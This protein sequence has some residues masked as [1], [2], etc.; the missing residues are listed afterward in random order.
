MK[1]RGLDS[2]ES[3]IVAAAGSLVFLL[4][5]CPMRLGGQLFVSILDHFETNRKEASFPFAIAYLMRSVS[6]PFAGFV[7]EKFGLRAVTIA[8]SLFCAIGVGGCFFAQNI[9]AVDI[10]LGLIYGIGFGWSTAVIPEIINLYFDKHRAKAQGIIFGGSGVG[11]FIIPPILEMILFGVGMSGTFLIISA[12]VLHSVPAAMLLTKR[13]PESSYNRKARVV[14]LDTSNCQ[15]MSERQTTSNCV[16]INNLIKEKNEPLSVDSLKS[17][18]EFSSFESVLEKDVL[19]N[20]ANEFHFNVGTESVT[21]TNPSSFSLENF[22]LFSVAQ[23]SAEKQKGNPMLLNG[24]NLNGQAA[25]CEMNGKSMKCSNNCCQKTSNKSLFNTLK[26]LWQPTFLVVS[27]IQSAHFYVMYIC[28]TIIV[29]VIRDKGID[30]SQE[31]Y[32]VMAMSFFDTIGRFCLTS[33]TDCGYITNSNFSAVCFAGMGLFC[34]LLTLVSGFYPTMVAISAL[35]L[36]YGGNTSGLPGIVTD[37]FNE[38]KRSMAMASRLTLYA[39]MSF[40]MSPLIGY[41]RGN[42]GSYN[43]LLYVMTSICIICTVTLILLPRILNH[44]INLPK[45]KK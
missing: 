1:R 8:G 19:R 10:F 32:F 18:V 4:A 29:D 2:I 21:K 38:E 7:G 28:W 35:G 3:W 30:Y 17:Y 12:I 9:I 40:T 11:A 6:G 33:V 14:E 41:F 15:T 5:T 24:A 20:K 13:L 31:V 45:A 27:F 36:M 43:G 44:K 22:N 37:F 25:S 39:P 23:E 34:F 26:I 16:N 42:L